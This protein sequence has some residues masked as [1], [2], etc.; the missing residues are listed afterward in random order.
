MY[1]GQICKSPLMHLRLSSEGRFLG[2]RRDGH[3]D[4]ICLVYNLQ[5]LYN[6]VHLK[7]F[8][9]KRQLYEE[10]FQG[11][12]PIGSP[13]PHW[14]S[15]DPWCSCNNQ[16]ISDK[17]V[18]LNGVGHCCRCFTCVSSILAEVLFLYF[19]N[20]DSGTVWWNNL[21]RCLKSA[22]LASVF[23]L[24]STNLYYLLVMPFSHLCQ[25]VYMW[26]SPSIFMASALHYSKGVPFV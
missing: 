3:Q 4:L 5:E 14:L 23:M 24:L 2:N 16:H 10:A 6:L 11:L 15:V 21:P 1:I 17:K 7:T 20:E 8:G 9:A 26:F 22:L 18:M 25:Y 12:V 19:R 13:S